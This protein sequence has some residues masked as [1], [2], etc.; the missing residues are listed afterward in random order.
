M[1]RRNKRIPNLVE[2]LLEQFNIS[3]PPIDVR[4]MAQDL[5]IQIR[6][7][8]LGDISGLIY[9]EGAKVIIGI[10]KNDSP[11]RRRFTIAHEL[12]HHF[13]HSQNPLFVDKVFAIQLRDHVSS[14]AVSIDEIE[15]NAFAAELLMPSNMILAD[16]Q[17][18]S[19]I[20]D[21]EK[22]DLSKLITQL[23]SRYNVST[24]AMNIR[25][26]KIG[27]IQNNI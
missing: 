3:S 8:D 5:D 4:K 11:K 14:E 27:I 17:A 19:T 25:F 26:I 13:L 23:A 7:D 9:R 22:G 16:I 6:E 20:L 21:Y 1:T 2:A 10:N 18:S 24:Q 12:G 15:A